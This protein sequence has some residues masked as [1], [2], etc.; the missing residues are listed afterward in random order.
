MTK[1][2]AALLICSFFVVFLAAQEGARDLKAVWQSDG[3]V[4]GVKESRTKDDS[5]TKL[6]QDVSAEAKESLSLSEN[7]MASSA[8]LPDASYIANLAKPTGFERKTF[9]SVD[10]YGGITGEFRY[11][12]PIQLPTIPGCPMPSLA[13]SY[14]SEGRN[15]ILGVGMNLSGLSS[16]DRDTSRAVK[17]ATGDGFLLDGQ[18]LV[19]GKDNR[20][21][22]ER[23]SYR[24]IKAN[25]LDSGSGDDY[26]EVRDK[27]GVTSLYGHGANAVNSLSDGYLKAV[28]PS[29]NGN[30]TGTLAR[31]WSIYSVLDLFG[32]GWSV[33]YAEDQEK[34]DPDAIYGMQYPL[35][36]TYGLRE[37]TALKRGTVDFF[38]T[39]RTDILR[40]YNPCFS[41][42]DLL[43]AWIVVKMDGS[44]VRK[45][46][47]LYEQSP[48]MHASRIDKIVEYGSDG[49][50]PQRS[51]SDRRL[52]NTYSIIGTAKPNTD[53]SWKVF[54]VS[55]EFPAIPDEYSSYKNCSLS[56]RL[57]GDFDGNGLQD[58]VYIMQQGVGLRLVKYLTKP[59]GITMKKEQQTGS[60]SGIWEN[61]QQYVGDFDGDGMD[62]IAFVRYTKSGGVTIRV[63][64]STSS[65]LSEYYES[66][67]GWGD[68]VLGNTVVG[69]I[70]GDGCDDL[71]F[72]WQHRT[73]GLQIRTLLGKQNRAASFVGVIS[74]PG[75]GPKIWNHGPGR[76]A[77]I[78]G[79]GCADLVFIWYSTTGDIRVKFGKTDGSFGGA[80]VTGP[81]TG[82]F[83]EMGD[84]NGD[85]KTDLIYVRADGIQV[86]L[87]NWTG[88]VGFT[89]QPLASQTFNLSEQLRYV[90][91][92][93]GDG[94]QDII[95]YSRDSNT[96]NDDYHVYYST[97]DGRTFVREVPPSFGINFYNNDG[98]TFGDWNA[99]GTLDYC[100]ASCSSDGSVITG[101]VYG[102]SSKGCENII[103]KI[104]TSSNAQICPGF[105]VSVSLPGV[106][107]SATA[108]YP[109]I[110]DK[111]SQRLMT[112]LSIA[113]SNMATQSSTISYGKRMLDKG[114]A[115]GRTVS[116]GFS[117][118]SI[119]DCVSGVSTKRDY[120]Q[121]TN[122]RLM[123][124]TESLIGSDSIVYQKTEYEYT[125]PPISIE[126]MNPSDNIQFVAPK[127]VTDTLR[128]SS[129]KIISLQ[130]LYEYDAYGN[131]T[132]EK[133]LGLS[134]PGDEVESHTDW[135]VKTLNW[136][137]APSKQWTLRSDS[138]GSLV[139]ES[140]TRLFYDNDVSITP[141]LIDKG[142]VTKIEYENG[143]T[144]EVEKFEYFLDGRKSKYW[145]RRAA[146]GMFG[147]DPTE[148]TTY[149]GG[150]GAFPIK[151]KDAFGHEVIYG[152]DLLMRPTT[153]T[154]PNSAVTA[155][156]Y[157][158]FGRM[159]KQALPLDS[160]DNP[161]VLNQYN[162][163]AVP[164]SMCTKKKDDSSDGYLVQYE[165]F[166]ELD[167]SIMT[168]GEAAGNF[169]IVCGTIYD[170]SSRVSKI[171]RPFY[172]TSSAYSPLSG[173]IGTVYAY[174]ASGRAC[175]ETGPDGASVRTLF[176]SAS[177]G[178]PATYSIDQNGSI[179]SKVERPSETV[180]SRY[181][182]PATSTTTAEIL[183]TSFVAYS[184]ITRKVIPGKVT[185][186]DSI[187]ASSEMTY[188]MLGRTVLLVDTTTGTTRWTYNPVTTIQTDAKNESLTI[189]YDRGGRVTQK[190]W[191]TNPQSIITYGY[192]ELNHGFGIGRPTSTQY[193]AGSDS[194]SYDSRG[195]VTSLSRTLGAGSRTLAMAYDSMD[196][197][198]TKTL[199]GGDEV[200][201]YSYDPSGRLFSVTSGTKTLS[202]NR[203]YDA[204]GALTAWI[205]S[206]TTGVSLAVAKDYYDEASEID[207]SSG[208][209][210]SG[211]LKSIKA[212][213]VKASG[214]TTQLKLSYE[215]DQAGNVKKRTDTL[216]AGRSQ[217]FTYDYQNRL[218]SAALGSIGSRSYSYDNVD[219]FTSKDGRSYTYGASP[220]YRITNDGVYSYLY[221]ADGRPISKTNTN[222]TTQ[223]SWNA[224]GLLDQISYPTSGSTETYSYDANGNRVKKVDSAGT[225]YYYFK[226]YEEVI[227]NG[228]T[229]KIK[230]YFADS[231]RIA[232]N[233]NGTLR[234]IVS[235]HLGSASLLVN[236]DGSV[237]R[238]QSYEPFGETLYTTG[239]AD[240][241]YTFTG[242]EL[243]DSGMYYFGARYHDPELGQFITPDPLVATM[244]YRSDAISYYTG[245]LNPYEYC[246]QNPVRFTD[247]TGLSPEAAAKIRIIIFREPESYTTR[248][249]G[250]NAINRGLDTM[251]LWNRETHNTYSLPV[252]TVSTVDPGN[253]LELGDF[254]LQLGPQYS[255]SFSPDVLT[256]QNATTV[257]G[258]S[259]GED[260]KVYEG[261]DAWRAHDNEPPDGNPSCFSSNG[262]ITGS[263]EAEQNIGTACDWL[264]EQGVEYGDSMQASLCDDPFKE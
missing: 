84:V 206:A 205:F 248:D 116:L 188:D 218:T 151:V 242:K 110:A 111:Q 135:A 60:G 194:Y 45:Y 99:D 100:A 124:S 20:W 26:W 98:V 137:M 225:T 58:I 101:F 9:A 167:R 128:T 165:Y 259:I 24:W 141:G 213:S 5:A 200:V 140:E 48:T 156:S 91:D 68:G 209:S 197:V 168:S 199:P 207:Q 122:L 34:A 61:G 243:D 69:D 21:H 226:E 239:A 211:L 228:T 71:V 88:D 201:S 82:V 189:T 127:S 187:G 231:D 219:R 227:A 18:K 247:Q 196:R 230:H 240:P 54:P 125:D 204:R 79:D 47:I 143:S 217:S 6:E 145:D 62:D 229:K 256:V 164:R 64:Y 104:T 255:S 237:A 144:D 32:N 52:F 171:I 152:Y 126:A 216:V 146:S 238:E 42:T 133:R 208:L 222:G 51:A 147:T 139:K 36:I 38:Y 224:A 40:D 94:Y 184:S 212:D 123:I 186:T 63:F 118:V 136:R 33:E 75:D 59:N 241:E 182:T 2:L 232:M 112:S 86:L 149:D 108:V 11:N 264:A 102:S 113:G 244:D 89:V 155:T 85:G 235:D 258:A 41:C 109:Q 81:N 7:A 66:T 77:D 142:L 234:A 23:E 210:N 202:G 223:M 183:D 254:Q 46:Q 236:T 173:K 131:V 8:P 195:R 134:A 119:L 193:G 44:L 246:A 92:A 153:V 150:Y 132:A 74:T 262:C 93:N 121:T 251:I 115:P 260:G 177:D 39:K 257:L 178:A 1:R 215:Y 214:T 3:P 161:T 17:F 25:N 250:G 114:T 55:M 172:A 191:G 50:V 35:T 252:Q 12:Y 154:D 43:L 129:T 263:T 80:T 31:S 162:D 70:N 49:N 53:F 19:L 15:G 198:K 261:G 90:Y 233:D 170:G 181:N 245:G 117:S 163:S 10:A 148:T 221:D 4:V 192:D 120:N 14:S 179:Q 130:T 190:A 95:V 78:N 174:D 96:N 180:M 175:R 13:I 203:T 106:I 159:A 83:P 29:E 67:T 158:L 166:D 107:D 16:I 27:D 157:D 169:W 30:P 37:G 138:S 97:G 28:I 22:T 65:G 57:T 87:S 176:G 56:R 105:A 72:P 160:L 249:A 103:E 253:T 220:S 76:I 185:L 73:L